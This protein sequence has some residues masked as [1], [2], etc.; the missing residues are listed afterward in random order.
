MAALGVVERE[1][2]VL[3]GWPELAIECLDIVDD[4]RISPALVD[5]VQN[6]LDGRQVVVDQSHT[7][8]L[9]TR[10][11]IGHADRQFRATRVD[12]PLN[13]YEIAHGQKVSRY[14]TPQPERKRQARWV[15]HTESGLDPTAGHFH[16]VRRWFDCHSRSCHKGD[17]EA[18]NPS[19]SAAPPHNTFDY[20]HVVIPDVLLVT[21]ETLGPGPFAGQSDLSSDHRKTVGASTQKL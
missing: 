20:F 1:G 14:L 8:D 7:T 5:D 9:Q 17:Q 13:P 15:T 10:L 11:R 21:R 3:R 4:W 6:P 16:L 2:T 19:R 12:F 18:N